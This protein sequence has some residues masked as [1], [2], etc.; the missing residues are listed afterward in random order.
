[1]TPA[2]IAALISL[3]DLVVVIVIPAL[4]LAIIKGYF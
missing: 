1:M 3:T 2:E 4:V